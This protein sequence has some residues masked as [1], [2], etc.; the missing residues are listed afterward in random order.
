MATTTAPVNT[1]S[2]GPIPDPHAP[3]PLYPFI[4]AT[5]LLC[6][7]LTTI[8]T[9]ARLITKRLVST[10]SYEDC[11]CY[12]KSPNPS[13]AANTQS[14]RFLDSGICEH[15]EKLLS[16]ETFLFANNKQV[17]NIAYNFVFLAAGRAGLGR[18]FSDVG[19]T[20]FPIL[21]K[22]TC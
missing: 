19:A 8:I 13:P 10:Y 7:I 22:V 11:G 4:L 3:N 15:A 1:P 2:L 18:H 20:G 16:A 14:C 6:S 12:S 9:A 17:F 21:A 5:V